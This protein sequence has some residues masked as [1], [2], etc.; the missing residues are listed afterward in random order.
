MVE[1]VYIY[2]V[3][4]RYN[5]W[6]CMCQLWVIHVPSFVIFIFSPESNQTGL[7]FWKRKLCYANCFRCR[8]LV[9]YPQTRR[10]FF[11]ET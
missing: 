5:F 7:F 11:L 6:P 2:H 3:I 8:L 10:V 4:Y 9:K 1:S